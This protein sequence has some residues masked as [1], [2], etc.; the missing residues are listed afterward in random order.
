MREVYAHFGVAVYLAQVIEHGVVNLLSVTQIQQEATSQ[1]DYDERVSAVFRKTFGALVKK[2][3]T[4]LD[5]DPGLVEDMGA[6]LEKRNYVVHRF[7]RERVQLTRTAQGRNRLIAELQE[8]QELFSS[9]DQR[10]DRVTFKYSEANGVT[11]QKVQELIRQ[12][13]EMAE[14]LGGYLLEELPDLGE[15][16]GE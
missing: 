16:R 2:L 5:E 13:R 10:V 7:W 9:V 15:A 8:L 4:Q 1:I 12:Q 3:G 14:A 6:A 11:R